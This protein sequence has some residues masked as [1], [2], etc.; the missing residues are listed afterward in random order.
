MSSLEGLSSAELLQQ[1]NVYRILD[2]ISVVLYT[3]SKKL[4]RLETLSDLIEEKYG[5]AA[6][7]R[8]QA[9]LEKQAKI[10][11]RNESA[12]E[13]GGTTTRRARAKR[14][15]NRTWPIHETEPIQGAR[16]R[17]GRRQ[18][19]VRWQAENPDTPGE[20]WVTWS[21]TTRSASRASTR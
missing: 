18:Y 11:V 5:E 2:G 13:V 3:V 16:T 10:R 8:N 7:D 17:H 1:I 19:L 20:V 9:W 12:E 21:T 14:N 6:R 4:A 15:D